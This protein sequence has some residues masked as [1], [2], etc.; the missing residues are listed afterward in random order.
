MNDYHCSNWE[1]MK[2]L[3]VNP[4]LVRFVYYGGVI[5]GYQKSEYW[6]LRRRWSQNCFFDPHG[7][8]I[9]S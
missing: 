9:P 6:R 1:T 5:S 3:S 7:T 2:F 4:A 8:S